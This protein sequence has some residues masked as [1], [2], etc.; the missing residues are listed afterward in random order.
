[1][2]RRNFFQRVAGAIAGIA[3]LGFKDGKVPDI[4]KIPPMPPKAKQEV[5]FGT[6]ST[7]SASVTLSGYTTVLCSDGIKIK[8]YT[9][10]PDGVLELSTDA[11]TD[12]TTD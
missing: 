7:S 8:E 6:F 3:G 9:M 10:R 1:M 11:K 4:P 5:V 12:K 2:N